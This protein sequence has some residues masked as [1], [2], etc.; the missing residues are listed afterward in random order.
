LVQNSTAKQGGG[1]SVPRFRN[2]RTYNKRFGVCS[3]WKQH[4]FRNK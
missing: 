3:Q 1:T 2:A 4:A